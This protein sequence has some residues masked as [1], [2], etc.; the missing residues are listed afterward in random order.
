MLC[1]PGSELRLGGR[2]NGRAKRIDEMDFF[3]FNDTYA[4]SLKISCSRSTMCFISILYAITTV[5]IR[6]TY[7]LLSVFLRMCYSSRTYVLFFRCVFSLG[8]Q[9]PVHGGI[10]VPEYFNMYVDTGEWMSS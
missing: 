1:D 6:Q 3:F 7:M 10:H 9:S 8:A 5:Y 4:Y 2:E